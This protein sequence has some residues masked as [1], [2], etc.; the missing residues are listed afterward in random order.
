METI[1]EAVDIEI[2]FKTLATSCRMIGMNLAL[3]IYCIKSN[4]DPFCLQ[5]GYD[6]IYGD[7][8]PLDFIESI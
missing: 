2:E 7:K 3:M 4:A 1:K 6:K 5:L 8:N